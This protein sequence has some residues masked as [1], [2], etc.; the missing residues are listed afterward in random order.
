MIG[1]QVNTLY[2]IEEQGIVSLD[3]YRQLLGK[4]YNVTLENNIKKV[5][6]DLN[7]GKIGCEIIIIA[8]KAFK[9]K[10]LIQNPLQTPENNGIEFSGL[11][12]IVV[13]NYLN[14]IAGFLKPYNIAAVENF[15]DTYL[16]VA[17]GK[18][19]INP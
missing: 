7:E 2:I 16:F 19:C 8:S 15:L 3:L 18:E 4:G 5:N 11:E 12:T 17:A 1:N 9:T 6:K 10:K 13:D 14:R